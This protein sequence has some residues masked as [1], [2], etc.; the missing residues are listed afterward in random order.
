M[1]IL[2]LRFIVYITGIILITYQKLR[3]EA[4]LGNQFQD[5]IKICLNYSVNG[6]FL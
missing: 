6:F 5:K 4:K 1:N 2:T 3:D